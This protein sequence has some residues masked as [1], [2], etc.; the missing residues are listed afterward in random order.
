MKLTNPLSRTRKTSIPASRFERHNLSPYG[1][2]VVFQK[3]FT[4]IG[5]RTRPAKCVPSATKSSRHASFSLLWS[6]LVFNALRG[7]DL[8]RDDPIVLRSLGVE[9]L[10]SVP[11]VSRRIKDRDRKPASKLEAQSAFPSPQAVQRGASARPLRASR[12]WIRLQVRHHQQAML[13]EVRRRFPRRTRIAGQ[14][15]RRAQEPGSLGRRALP[16]PDDKPERHALLDHDTTSATS[17]S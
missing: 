5:L 12:I 11:T 14:R 7:I 10:P 16:A 17:S 13:A 3:L 8:N 2:L 1:R 15:L 6:P 9:C 4:D